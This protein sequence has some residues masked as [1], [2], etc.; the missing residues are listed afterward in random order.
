MWLP[1]EPLKTEILSK[2]R[3]LNGCIIENCKAKEGHCTCEYGQELHNEVFH[4][5]GGG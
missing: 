4:A 2:F 5:G 1:S 3:T